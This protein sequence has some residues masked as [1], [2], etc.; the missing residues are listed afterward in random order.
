[1]TSRFAGVV[2]FAMRRT[3]CRTAGI[4]AHALSLPADDRKPL[5]EP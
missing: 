2:A 4:G 1:M 5:T 3:S